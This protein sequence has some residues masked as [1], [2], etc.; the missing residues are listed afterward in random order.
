MSYTN[1]SA[2]S[3]FF[4]DKKEDSE[5]NFDLFT[6][7]YLTKILVYAFFLVHTYFGP[8]VKNTTQKEL[9]HLGPSFES[10]ART[11]ISVLNFFIHMVIKLELFSAHFPLPHS[12]P[13]YISSKQP[14]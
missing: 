13:N 2:P 5:K 3:Q 12:E 6:N 11:Y 4:R 8:P 7:F 1:N 9:S 14:L 10:Y